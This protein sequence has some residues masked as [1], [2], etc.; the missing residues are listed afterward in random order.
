MRGHR[1]VTQGQATKYEPLVGS[2]SETP[3]AS[4]KRF[5]A[6]CAA[7]CA[8]LCKDE[9]GAEAVIRARLA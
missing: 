5:I 7:L 6:L 2:G 1:D 9:R 4:L 8:A 3:P